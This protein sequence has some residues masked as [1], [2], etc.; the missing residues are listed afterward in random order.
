MP[1]WPL[2]PGP[3]QPGARPLGISL[4]IKSGARESMSHGWAPSVPRALS[5]FKLPVFIAPPLLCQEFVLSSK[6]QSPLWGGERSGRGQGEDGKNPACDMEHQPL[7]CMTQSPMPQSLHPGTAVLP[8]TPSTPLD[9]GCPDAPCSEVRCLLLCC[10]RIAAASCSPHHSPA[11]CSCPGRR[12]SILPLQHPQPAV[13]IPCEAF[14][15][16]PS[17]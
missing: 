13:S 15:P 5:P 10:S 3:G 17:S 7:P 12:H 2:P 16:C 6:I 8:N 1:H 4:P 14:T 9:P 11:R